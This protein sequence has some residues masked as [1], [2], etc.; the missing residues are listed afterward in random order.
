MLDCKP[1]LN[2]GF[3]DFLFLTK[4][5]MCLDNKTFPSGNK[6]RQYDEE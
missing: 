1:S 5:K 3:L 4:K 2:L 6:P